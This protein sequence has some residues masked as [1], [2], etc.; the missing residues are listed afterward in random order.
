MNKTTFTSCYEAALAGLPENIRNDQVLHGGLGLGGY[1][2]RVFLADQLRPDFA[3]VLTQLLT[4][5]GAARFNL[6][7]YACFDCQ[8]LVA[9]SYV[10][11]VASGGFAALCERMPLR[12]L[13]IEKV[14]FE[15][16]GREITPSGVRSQAPF[17]VS[18]VI[19]SK[20]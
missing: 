10:F 8:R 5:D 12:G 19:Y 3:P 1:G 16:H 9:V 13:H 18:R 2:G 11:K 6:H 15:S 7:L 20:K 4:S 17:G 14:I